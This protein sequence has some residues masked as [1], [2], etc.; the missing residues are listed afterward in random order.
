MG[1]EI[2]S[3]HSPIEA[4]V[5]LAHSHHCFHGSMER[6]RQLTQH[7]QNR[8]LPEMTAASRRTL[9]ACRQSELYPS[10]YV[11]LDRGRWRCCRNDVSSEL[12]VIHNNA[13]VNVPNSDGHFEIGISPL[14]TREAAIHGR[15]SNRCW[16]DFESRRIDDRVRIVEMG[17]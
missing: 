6:F 5:L 4:V 14:E 15:V 3:R 8:T 12:E 1:S 9:S 11:L 17:V 2:A 16:S 13:K 7:H 10:T